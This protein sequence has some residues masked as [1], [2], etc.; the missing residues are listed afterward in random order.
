[1]STTDHFQTRVFPSAKP[2][3]PQKTPLSILDATVGRFAPSSAIWLFEELPEGIAE[4]LFLDTLQSAF[5]EA[6]GA[7]PQWAGQLKWAEARPGGKHTERFNRPELVWG[8][9][10]DPGVEWNTV[11]HPLLRMDAVVPG[12]AERASGTGVWMA[13]DFPQVSFFQNAAPPHSPFHVMS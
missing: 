2:E 9:A 10:E 13:T 1:M 5:V 12:P 7:F 8:T 4:S 11:K 6:L 3:Q